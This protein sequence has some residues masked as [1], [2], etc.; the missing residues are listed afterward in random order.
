MHYLLCVLQ[1]YDARVE[2][3]QYS[4]DLFPGLRMDVR[5]ACLH[6]QPNG[7]AHFVHYEQ[8]RV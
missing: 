3:R 6:Q 1:A 8:V 4:E 2:G 5:A 7:V